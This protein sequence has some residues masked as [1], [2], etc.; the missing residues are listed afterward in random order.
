MTGR[1]RTALITARGFSVLRRAFGLSLLCLV[2]PVA[3][4]GEQAGADPFDRV[5]FWIG[6]A[7]ARFVRGAWPGR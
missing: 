3:G 2:A 7:S 1:I 5:S 4:A 6:L